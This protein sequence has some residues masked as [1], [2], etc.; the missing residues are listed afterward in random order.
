MTLISLGNPVCCCLRFKN[1]ELNQDVQWWRLLRRFRAGHSNARRVL[2]TD[3][4]AKFGANV[5]EDL[6]TKFLDTNFI[7]FGVAT[8]ELFWKYF[9]RLSLTWYSIFC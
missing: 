7:G 3:I 9:Y 4:E 8:A 5:A 6:R 1:V 2:V